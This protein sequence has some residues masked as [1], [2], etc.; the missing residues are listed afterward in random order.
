MST[1]PTPIRLA[2][3]IGITSSALVGGIAL[4]NSI[5]LV[6]AML[7][8]PTPLL[9]TQFAHVHRI[10]GAYMPPLSVAPVLS[11]LYL[12]YQQRRLTSLL[13]ASSPGAPAQIWKAY[14]AAGAIAAAF[15]PYTVL[16]I[17]P[18]NRKLLAREEE[19]RALKSTDELTQ[20][21]MAETSHALL[22]WWGV[23]NLGRFV[24]A[25]AAAAVGAWASL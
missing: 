4:G 15:L 1:T 10:G 6:P 11:F 2:Q 18:T 13:E 12:A 23:L 7:D 22:D 21:G 25:G 17:L 5:F 3:A 8:S 20:A 9:H 16:C 19:T 14:L 24:I